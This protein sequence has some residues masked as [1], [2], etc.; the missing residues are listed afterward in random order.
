MLFELPAFVNNVARS[1]AGTVDETSGT[2]SLPP[3]VTTVTVDLTH[4]L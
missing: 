4:S 3:N 1:T 2:V